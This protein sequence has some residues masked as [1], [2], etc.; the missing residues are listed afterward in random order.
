MLTGGPCISPRDKI[1][2]SGACLCRRQGQDGPGYITVTAVVPYP[3]SVTFNDMVVAPTLDNTLGASSQCSRRA[4]VSNTLQ[5]CSFWAT[6]CWSG[7]GGATT[8]PPPSVCFF[9][10]LSGNNHDYGTWGSESVENWLHA[11]RSEQVRA[12]RVTSYYG[13]TTVHQQ[14]LGVLSC[15]VQLCRHR[16]FLWFSPVLSSSVQKQKSQYFVCS[17]DGLSALTA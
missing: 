4:T 8:P 17:W 11:L 7:G 14:S 6:S 15:S 16:T 9:S 12:K 5:A 2:V 3:P 10:F 1:D 13:T